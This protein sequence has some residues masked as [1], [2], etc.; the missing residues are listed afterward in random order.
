[1]R[2]SYV[3]LA[4]A[5]LLS[6]CDA[7][8]ATIGADVA[9]ATRNNILDNSKRFLRSHGSTTGTKKSPTAMKTPVTMKSA[10]SVFGQ[11]LD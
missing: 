7:A 2:A 4:V 10:G 8:A 9:D 6:T 3:L 5:T 1:M 11:F